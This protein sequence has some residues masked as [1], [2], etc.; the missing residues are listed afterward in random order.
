[1]EAFMDWL[2]RSTVIISVFFLLYQLLRFDNNFLRNRIFLISGII[3]STVLPLLHF[4]LGAS[5]GV[6]AV[7]N[8][9]PITV[10]ASGIRTA[11][12]E[13]PV[14]FDILMI[15]YLAGS[16]YLTARLLIQLISI[17]RLARR[18]NVH[19]RKGYKVMIT[20]EATSPFSFMNMIFVHRMPDSAGSS[21]IFSHERTHAIHWH[22]A[23]VVLMELFMIVQW[24]NPLVWIYRT[25]LREVHEY[26]ADQA[27]INS[28]VTKHQ[29]LRLLLSVA[30]SAD[31]KDISNN[32]CQIKLKRRLSMITKNHNSRL[33]GFKFALAC[34]VLAPAL[35]LAS[36]SNAQN[37]NDQ[38]ATGNEQPGGQTGDTTVYTV[39]ENMPV[40]PGGDEARVKFIIQNVKYPQAAKEK[41]IQGTVLVSFI[42]EADGAV[43]DVKVVRGVGS[44][45][46]EEAMRVVKLMP[47]WTPGKQSGK[48]VRV[49]FNMPIKFAL[50]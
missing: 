27:T 40:Y 48:A 37:T 49:Q 34:I 28:G 45:C 33:S 36:C 7:V 9:E 31:P 35:W 30:V 39:V 16:A 22:S 23:D 32:F 13:L 5:S 3:V 1:M 26:L 20:D 2:F 12:V 18:S 29:Y 6:S 46:D 15:I 38:S 17:L 21:A 8:L 50:S 41:G 4:N 43:A 11:M 24:F 14:L 19:S 42:V 47:K 10:N 44:G 25:Q